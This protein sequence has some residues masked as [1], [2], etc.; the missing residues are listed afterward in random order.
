MGNCDTRELTIIKQKNT[1]TLV[2]KKKRELEKKLQMK[3]NKEIEANK[4]K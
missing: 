3:V 2:R 1:P 4:A